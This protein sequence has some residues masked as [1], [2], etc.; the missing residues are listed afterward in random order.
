MQD[1]LVYRKTRRGAA[2][3]AATHG[4]L[5]H[6]ARRVLILLDGQRTLA[7]L[8]ELFGA[9][10]VD[11]IVGDL[12]A[13]GF[14][15][16]VDPADAGETT[17]SVP[18]GAYPP[19]AST[20]APTRPVTQPSTRSMTPPLSSPEA[21]PGASRRGAWV[22]LLV[23]FAAAGAGGYSW[24][25]GRLRP[26]T[27]AAVAVASVVEPERAA[28]AATDESG[29]GRDAPA[30][31]REVPLSGLPAVT[32]KPAGATTP[33][34][35][36]LAAP[37]GATRGARGADAPARERAAD[38]PAPPAPA[39]AAPAPAA[40]AEVRPPPEAP[41]A[42]ALTVAPAG[43]AR[44]VPVS[45]AANDGARIE[46]KAA[47]TAPP[48]AAAVSPVIAPP[49]PA[50]APVPAAPP[51]QLAALAPSTP[52]RSAAVQL[53][54]RRHDPPEYPGRALRA[55]IYGG[56]VLARIWVNPEG[57]VEQV[58]IVKATPP[59][60]FDDEV[61]RALSLWT[62]DPPGRAVDTTVELDF[63]P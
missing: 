61:K 16:Q 40:T 35:P 1:A 21:E 26:A 51:E 17:Q 56:H 52:P 43:P 29:T 14:A 2:E 63:K 49:A 62:F 3:L 24:Y 42:T 46:R 4:R 32:V 57:G 54:Q 53:H 31:V 25:S 23:V 36:A 38:E 9:E 30:E 15:R 6:S 8:A 39:A 13:Q 33:A 19:L 10:A 59:R 28:P 41:A 22:L 5:S 12:E 45:L 11:Q 50:A 55:K 18:I 60:L 58:D 20:Q 34:P 27:D 48:A 37:A 44:A 47:E 7:E